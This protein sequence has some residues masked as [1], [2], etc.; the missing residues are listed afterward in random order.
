[1]GRRK[2]EIQPITHERN[3]SVTFLKRK[4]GLFKKA[5]ELG[6]LC[7]IDVAVIIFEDR[8]GHELKLHQYCS[9]DIRDI[10][11][12]QLRHAGEKDLKGPNDFSGTAAVDADGDDDAPEEEEEPPASSRG[13]RKAAVAANAKLSMPSDIDPEYKPSHRN[14]PSSAPRTRRNASAAPTSSHHGR[15]DDNNSV[16]SLLPV[17][18]DRVS[19]IRESLPRASKRLR[20]GEPARSTRSTAHVS[21]PSRSPSTDGRAPSELYLPDTSQGSPGGRF[22]RHQDPGL[23]LQHPYSG[24]GFNQPYNPLF[25]TGSHAS[26]PPQGFGAGHPY[27]VRNGYGHQEEYDR[28]GAYGQHSGMMRP[29]QHQTGYPHQMKEERFRDERDAERGRFGA[30]SGASFDRGRPRQV[31]TCSQ[32][33]LRR[34]RGV[35]RWKLRRPN[36]NSTSRTRYRWI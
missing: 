9:G 24:Q 7:S 26:P 15:F 1:M 35:D 19:S 13:K 18:N 29:P 25:P 3:R 33:S 10:V 28:S 36:A 23:A 11:Q 17:S 21:A 31:Q 16:S 20:T 5:Y 34:T 6:V 14:G 30:G 27:G 4:N 32:C 12:R 2:I 22:G 8:P